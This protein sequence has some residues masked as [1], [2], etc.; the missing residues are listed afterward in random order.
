MS[1]MI[2]MLNEAFDLYIWAAEFITV[3]DMQLDQQLSMNRYIYHD[4]IRRPMYGANPK[5]IRGACVNSSLMRASLAGVQRLCHELPGREMILFQ[6]YLKIIESTLANEEAINQLPEDDYLRFKKENKS[7][8]GSTIP[9]EIHGKL[10][11]RHIKAGDKNDRSSKKN[12]NDTF[13]PHYRE[14]FVLCHFT[15]AFSGL[16]HLITRIPFG[17]AKKCQNPLWHIQN[18]Q[19]PDIDSVRT[20]VFL[21]LA[22]NPKLC[23][24]N[25]FAVSAAFYAIAAEATPDGVDEKATFYWG[26]AANMTQSGPI[27]LYEDYERSYEEDNTRYF[28]PTV[29][30]RHNLTTLRWCVSKALKA[31]R[32]RDSTMY[33]PSS[34]NENGS[35]KTQSLKLLEFWNECCIASKMKPEDFLIPMAV[36]DHTGIFNATWKDKK[37]RQKK[38]RF[39]LQ[40]EIERDKRRNAKS[41]ENCLAN[42]YHELVEEDKIMHEYFEK[43]N[44]G[45]DKDDDSNVPS[46]KHLALHALQSN[47]YCTTVDDPSIAVSHLLFGDEEKEK[48]KA[49][50]SSSEKHKSQTDAITIFCSYC[51]SSPSKDDKPFSRC[52]RCKK[53]YYCSVKCQK[54][55][56]KKHKKV[57]KK[58]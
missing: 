27:S 17:D 1:M 24:A 12:E 58:V 52:S 26:A 3:C 32:A 35:F 10:N 2:G 15:R 30:K 21:G 37:G 36:I 54:K 11:L 39:S 19:R 43:S 49:K 29:I 6:M 33:G 25:M 14:A 40:D 42:N 7:L 46:L 23:K 20:N 4:P 48:A 5:N 44:D 50:V 31:E 16:A 51:G 22:D 56:W 13:P 57:C 34:R 28:M 45:G 55:D 53:V 8:F 41:L 38:C 9:I 47:G 18:F